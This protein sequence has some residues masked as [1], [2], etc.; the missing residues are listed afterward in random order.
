[1]LRSLAFYGVP[2]TGARALVLA[3]LFPP[4][5]LLGSSGSRLTCRSRP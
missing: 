4:L 2:A 3:Q 5:W 1:M